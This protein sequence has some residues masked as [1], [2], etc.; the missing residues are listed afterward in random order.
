M[1]CFTAANVETWLNKLISLDLSFLNCYG[2]VVIGE[3]STETLV[4]VAVTTAINNYPKLTGIK[5]KPFYCAKD[6]VG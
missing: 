6:S 1:P 5:Q 3:D 2:R 4:D